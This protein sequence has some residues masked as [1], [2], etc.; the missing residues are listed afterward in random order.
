MKKIILASAIAVVLAGC[1]GSSDGSS[2]GDSYT[3]PFRIS[4][5]EVYKDDTPRALGLDKSY[6]F[7]YGEDNYLNSVT[8]LNGNGDVTSIHNYSFDETGN[9]TVLETPDIKNDFTYNAEG[10]MLTSERDEG[11]NGSYESVTTYSYNLD[12]GLAGYV[13]EE[14]VGTTSEEVRLTYDAEGKLSTI[15]YDSEADS[16]FEE[17]HTM[18]YDTNG[19]L[20]E[21]E[22]NDGGDYDINKYFH[23]E[24][25]KL[26]RLERDGDADGTADSVITYEYDSYG[27]LI[28]VSSDENMDG[29]PEEETIITYEHGIGLGIDYPVSQL[30]DDYIYANILFYSLMLDQ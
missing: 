2:T 26:T 19:Y 20:S 16:V 1:G 18:S 27:N 30:Y 6:E 13:V 9:M 17:L 15:E 3:G 14:P 10:N 25:G 28:T 22:I 24:N 11:K 23:D 5:V 4:N 7:T 29:T 8:Y 12:D 21:D